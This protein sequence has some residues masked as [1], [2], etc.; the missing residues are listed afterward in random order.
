MHASEGRLARGVRLVC[1][2]F[3][4]LLDF[5]LGCIFQLLYFEEAFI[6]RENEMAL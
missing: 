2:L 5:R 1:L 3:S 4:L 6:M